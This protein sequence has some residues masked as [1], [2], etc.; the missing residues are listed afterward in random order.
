MTRKTV[1]LAF[2]L[3]LST[4]RAFQGIYRARHEMARFLK[5]K[6]IIPY[7]EDYKVILQFSRRQRLALRQ[8][9]SIFNKGRNFPIFSNA[10]RP[11]S[12]SLHKIETDLLQFITPVI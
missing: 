11:T 2:S 4:T 1:P 5:R 8:E 12:E 10:V 6:R 3:S 9:M 7:R